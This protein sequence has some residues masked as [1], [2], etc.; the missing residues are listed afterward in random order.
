MGNGTRKI[1]AVMCAIALV[2]S[3]VT[4]LKKEN[5]IADTNYAA[6]TYSTIACNGAE[7]LSLDYCV[8]SN[9]LLGYGD[10]W[11]GDGGITFQIVFSGAVLA[12][13]YTITVNGEEPATGVVSLKGNGLVK[14][15]PTV[16]ADN[17]YYDILITRT[18]EAQTLN[19]VLKKGTPSGSGETISSGTTTTTTAPEPTTDAQGYTKVVN[20]WIT[21]GNF[22]LF[23]G[24]TARTHWYLGTGAYN[25][26]KVKLQG[27][28]SAE[29]DSQ[30]GINVAGLTNG[31]QYDYEVVFS[32]NTSGNIYMQIP[33]IVRVPTS[34]TSSVTAG[35]NTFTGTFTAGTNPAHG[36][37]MLFPEGMPDGTILDFTSVT[38]TEHVDTPDPDDRVKT[39]TT[40][41]DLV[42]EGFQI[43]TNNAKRGTGFRM[44]AKVPNATTIV[45]DEGVSHT[46][47]HFGTVYTLD[48]NNTGVDANNT[49]DKYDTILDDTGVSDKAW[50][51]EGVNNGNDTV[52]FACTAE[53]F[54]PKWKPEDTTHRYYAMT[55]YDIDNAILEHTIF[56]RPYFVDT[57]GNIVYAANTYV[58][59]MAKVADDLYKNSKMP[60]ATA[61]E[62]LYSHILGHAVFTQH[63][64]FHRTTRLE[65]GYGSGVYVPTQP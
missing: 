23:P 43:N 62:Y 41:E 11:Y 49:Y 61:H 39:C 17:N 25:D 48:T 58:T 34:G 21:V 22:Q 60:N 27:T 5:V 45:D 42:V 16:L 9:N 50:E 37:I 52:G 10:V 6:L 2:I 4:I 36:Q 7:G 3:S 56:V 14:L 38:V 30:I 26:M 19:I 1:I 8:V 47:A 44:I 18:D 29:Y 54:L 53:A 55:M 40:C 33:G 35:T 63:S 31:T 12:E 32:S 20:G 59:S 57:A 46:V 28:S 65:Y 15:N 13:N 64:A 24:W 51:F